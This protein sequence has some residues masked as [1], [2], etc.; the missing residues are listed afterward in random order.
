MNFSIFVLDSRLDVS[1]FGLCFYW[2]LDCYIIDIW[3]MCL[4]VS[5][6]IVYVFDV[7]VCVCV[8]V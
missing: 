7:C 1:T 3:I 6:L 5:G 8:C 4:F 2:I